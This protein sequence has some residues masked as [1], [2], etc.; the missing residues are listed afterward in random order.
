MSQIAVANTNYLSSALKA[1]NAGDTLVL[2]SGDYQLALKGLSFASDVTIKAAAGAHVSFSRV[3]AVDVS[4]VKFDGI[5]FDQSAKSGDGKAFVFRDTHGIDIVNSTF[6]GEVKGGYGSGTGIFVSGGDDFTL[7]NSSLSGFH[8][9]AFFLGVTGLNVS[10]NKVSEIS[11]DAMITG[12]VHDALFDSNEV[13]LHVQQGTKHSDGMQFW[14]TGPNEP[15]TNLTIRNNLVE[16]HNDHSH[17]IYMMNGNEPTYG[18]AAAFH[19]VTIEHNTVVS[20]QLSGLAWGRTDGLDIRD[21]TVLQDTAFKSDAVISTPA[22]RVQNSS[23]DVAITGNVTH[24]A[25]ISTK[26]TNWSPDK[27]VN[28]AWTVEHNTIVKRGTLPGESPVKDHDDDTGGDTGGDDE[29]GNGH[30]DAFRIDGAKNGNIKISGVDFS[31]GDQIRLIHFQTD[32]FDFVRGGNK[33][34]VSDHG[35]FAAINSLTDLQEL[36][37]SSTHLK[38]RDLGDS[39]IQITISETGNDKHVITLDHMAQDFNPFY[40]SLNF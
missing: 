29:G 30:S 4:N 25:P 12:K 40:D 11:L 1:A 9:G 22:I 15:S 32:T 34:A 26:F 39:G 13:S 7:A 33:L 18:K 10:H 16:T 27:V 19:D 36:D 6:D 28:P 17:G 14:N 24:V 8:T 3:E 23:T 20:G 2:S 5:L 38:I 35:S 31:E 21:N 37:A